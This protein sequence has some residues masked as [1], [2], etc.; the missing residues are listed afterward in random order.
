MALTPSTMV[1]L[2]TPAPA[3]S[4]PS[5]D[6]TTV[7]LDSFADADALLVMFIC[8]HCPFVVHVGEGLARLAKDYQS[9]G[10]AVAA[11]N[12]NDV[13]G[14]PDDSPE[15]M[16]RFAN[17]YGFTFPYL[18]DETQE[19]ARAFG[20]T[21]TPHVFLLDK[22]MKVAY[23]GAIDDSSRD[24]AAVDKKYVEDA[25]AALEAGKEPDPNFTKAIGCS[26]KFK[27]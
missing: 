27:K 18:F 12:A 22:D 3:F 5:T 21:K 20:A 2:G 1:P 14:Y 7:S 17:D 24:P 26:I 11:I 13:A 16:V 4:L 9:K 8:N 6:G 23:I 15:N 25:I 19:V 10:V